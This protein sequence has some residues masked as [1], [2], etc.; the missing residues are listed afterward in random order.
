MTPEVAAR[1]GAAFGSFVRDRLGVERPTFCVGRDSRPSGEMIAAAAGSGLMSVGCNL[2]DLGIVTTP[3][4]A[5]MIGHHDADG[6]MV[7]TASHNPIMWNGLKSLNADGVAPPSADAAEI[8]RRF[9]ESDLA[10]VPVDQLGARRSDASTDR[11]HVDRVLAALD[12]EPIRAAGFTVVLDSVNGA[13]CVAGRMLLE[14]LGCTVV[15]MNG[16]P[17][18]HFAHTPE[19]IEANLSDLM[20]ETPAR[21]ADV[22]FAQDPDADRLVVV[23]E[24]G[25]FIGEEYTLVLAVERTL[26]VHGGGTMAV[27]LSTSRMIDDVAAGVPGASV[28]R[29]AVGEANV[30]SALKPAGGLI[31]GEGNGGVIFP[32]VCW[33]RDSLSS[34]ALVLSLMAARREPLHAIVDRLPRYEMIKQTYDLSDIGGRAVVDDI[35]AAVR[36]ANADQRVNDA[37][38]LRVDRDAFWVHVRPSNTEPILRLIAEGRTR[39]DAEAGIQSVAEVI[40]SVTSPGAVGA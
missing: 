37:D 38:G 20:R 24:N 9:Q 33:V 13:G 34:M 7:V 36:Q 26:E 40:T 15:H 12:P 22:G 27:N 19:P 6:G 32:P 18:G 11:L 31:G 35:L 23:D 3:S 8:I 10:Y 30:V 39:A 14:E 17:T 1:F 25:R 21:G 29:T 4:V 16:E 5:V 28:L 2:I